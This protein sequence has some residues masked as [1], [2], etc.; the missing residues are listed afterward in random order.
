MSVENS[1]FE[2]LTAALSPAVLDVH[3]DSHLHQ[4]HVGSPGTGSS[5]FRIEV[6][7]EKFDGLGRLDRHRLINDALVDE[8]AGPVHALSIV[9]LTPGEADSRGA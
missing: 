4:G 2:K 7:S 3:N 6:V 1:I 8:L 9:A 5:H